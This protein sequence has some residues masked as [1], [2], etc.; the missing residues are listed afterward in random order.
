MFHS[1]DGWFFYRLKYGR[2]MI[3]K[4]DG[5][6]KTDPLIA[7]VYLSAEEW[8]SIVAAVSSTGEVNDRFQRALDFH[9]N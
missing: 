4:H 6:K 9:Q 3:E 5:A 7:S 2:V 1:K 8:A